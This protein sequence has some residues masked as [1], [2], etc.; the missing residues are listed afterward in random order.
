MSFNP[1]TNQPLIDYKAINEQLKKEREEKYK[2]EVQNQKEKEQN[3][4][5]VNKAQPIEYN[6]Y[7]NY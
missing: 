4:G 1:I 3:Y 2:N 6:P 7:H 5:N